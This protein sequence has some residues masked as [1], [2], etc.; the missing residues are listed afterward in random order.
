MFPWK[1][2]IFQTHIA[3]LFKTF[4]GFLICFQSPLRSSS[5]VH[6]SPSSYTITSAL[7]LPQTHASFMLNHS[8]SPAC[9]LFRATQPYM[10]WSLSLVCISPLDTTPPQGNFCASTEVDLNV[11]PWKKYVLP[12]RMYDLP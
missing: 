5:H 11:I 10:C 1:R 9:L 12:R 6:M 8:G 7:S 3:H 2:V 4:I